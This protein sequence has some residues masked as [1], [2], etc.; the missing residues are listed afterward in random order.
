[1]VAGGTERVHTV[2]SY[3]C[4]ECATSKVAE[5]GVRG[6][7]ERDRNL[8]SHANGCDMDGGFL[9]ESFGES[10]KADES[11]TIAGDNQI[12]YRTIKPGRDDRHA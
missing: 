5:Q 2:F 10:S 1:M 7:A 11:T 3:L 9:C 12:A 8:H 6:H 4:S